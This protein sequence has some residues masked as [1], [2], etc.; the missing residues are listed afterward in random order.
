MDG[1]LS[2]ENRES[3]WS[4]AAMAAAGR[5]GKFKDARR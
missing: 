5:I 3:P 1:N 4:P 2:H